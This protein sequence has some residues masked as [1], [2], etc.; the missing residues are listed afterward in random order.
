MLLVSI[1]DVGAE[2]LVA[3]IGRHIEQHREDL[4]AEVGVRLQPEAAGI[5]R[6]LDAQVAAGEIGA[7]VRCDTSRQFG[8]LEAGGDCLHDREPGPVRRVEI[9]PRGVVQFALARDATQRRGLEGQRPDL[10][11]CCRRQ[12]LFQEPV[13]IGRGVVRA[14]G[15]APRHARDDVGGGVAGVGLGV[16]H[17]RMSCWFSRPTSGCRRRGSGPLARRPTERGAVPARRLTVTS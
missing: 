6:V 2:A 8:A 5:L 4:H 13:R 7:E 11:S 14:G 16:S 10:V 3:R 15:D 12:A 1:V 9:G 17:G